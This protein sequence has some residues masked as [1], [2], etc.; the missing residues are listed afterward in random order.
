MT[1]RYP[2]VARL[3]GA[4]RPS[5]GTVSVDRSSLLFT[6]RPFRRRRTYTLHLADVAT[7][8]VQRILRAELAEKSAAK[9]AARRRRR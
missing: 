3:D 5:E 4:G 8:V 1:H 2:V 6:V 7:M 9:K